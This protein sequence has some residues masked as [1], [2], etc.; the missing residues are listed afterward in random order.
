[1]SGSVMEVKTTLVQDC[2]KVNSTC[3]LCVLHPQLLKRNIIFFKCFI[4]VFRSEISMQTQYVLLQIHAAYHGW[5][6]DS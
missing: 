1:M 6:F 4:L 3:L 2:K 5:Q